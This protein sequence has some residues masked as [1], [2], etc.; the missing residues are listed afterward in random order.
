MNTIDIRKMS[1][2]ERLQAMD[3]KQMQLGSSAKFWKLIEK[4]RKE[5]TIGRA[6]LEPLPSAI[7]QSSQ[8]VSTKRRE[9][10]ESDGTAIAYDVGF[11][12]PPW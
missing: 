4:W 8:W 3:E 6:E 11:P 7:F 1:R 9:N 12:T 5:K 2:I 10:R